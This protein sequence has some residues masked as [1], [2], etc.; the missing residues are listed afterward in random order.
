MS[1]TDELKAVKTLYSEV[2]ATKKNET[3]NSSNSIC[4]EL[5]GMQQ[6]FLEKINNSQQGG[7][8]DDTTGAHG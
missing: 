8:A 6:S 1:L 7:Q 2:T 5:S 3:A 4:E